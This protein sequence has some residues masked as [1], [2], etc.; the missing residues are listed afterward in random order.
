MDQQEL[1]TLYLAK[2]EAGDYNMY[3]EEQH[4]A[5]KKLNESKA[6]LKETD[7]VVVKIAEKVINNEDT[8]VLKNQ[9]QDILAKRVVLRAEI[10]NL[11]LP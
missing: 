7:W 11:E 1:Q 4:E 8:S 2:L 3:T 5:I 10:N 9:Y 6:Y